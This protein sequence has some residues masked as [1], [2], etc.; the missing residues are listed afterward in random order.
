MIITNSIRT[1]LAVGLGLTALC[2]HADPISSAAMITGPVK[3]ITFDGF[4]NLVTTGPINVGAEVG[5]NVLFSSVPNSVVGAPQRDLGDNGQWG[6]RGNPVDGLVDTPT[7]SGNFLASAFVT[8]RGEFGFS[9]ANPVFAVGAFMNQ[10]QAIGASN[11]RL[12]LIAYDID[13]NELE[14]YTQAPNTSPLG[15]NEGSFYGI[16]RAAADIYGFGVADG[17]LVLDNLTYA[18]APVPEPSTYALLLA[19]VGVV[20]WSVSR[21]RKK[22]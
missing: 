5:D 13:G 15:S 19:G 10:F 6:G 11:N 14:S 22:R 17:N 21:N 9:F 2:V 16:R 1:A 7:G 20:G 8:R 12:V 3:V 18:T 4:D